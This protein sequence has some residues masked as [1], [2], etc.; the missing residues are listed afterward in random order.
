M[1][2]RECGKKVNE[3][4]VACT[5]CGVNPKLSKNFCGACGVKTKDNQIVCLKCGVSLGGSLAG[6]SSGE[7]SKIIAC[8]LALFLGTIGVHKFYL[9]YNTQGIIMLLISTVGFILWWILW[10]TPNFV[11]SVIA[12]IEAIMYISKSDEEFQE[13]YV[14]N[15]KPWF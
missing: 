15:E 6:S 12:L 5:G 2:C 11:I 1:Y 10:F 4:A 7:K 13:I 3:N 9:G 14:D 8:L